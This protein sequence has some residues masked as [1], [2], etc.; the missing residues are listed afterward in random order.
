MIASLSDR[1]FGPFPI[2]IDLSDDTHVLYFGHG[3]KPHGGV[4]SFKNWDRKRIERSKFRDADTSFERRLP[5]IQLRVQAECL[6]FIEATAINLA[7]V[8]ELKVGRIA[9]QSYSGEYELS[10]FKNRAGHDVVVRIDKTYRPAFDRYLEFRRRVFGLHDTNLLF[11]FFGKGGEKSKYVATR[12]FRGLQRIFSSAGR[13]FV[14]PSMLRF[15]KGQRVIRLAA[16]GGDLAAVSSVLQ[17][18][19]DVVMRSYLVG[20]Q[21]M[22][23]IEFSKFLKTVSEAR[24]KHQVRAGGDCKKPDEPKAIPGLTEGTPKPD[25]INPAGCFFCHHYRG[26]KS[27]DYLHKILSYRAFLRLRSGLAASTS[28]MVNEVIVPTIERINDYAEEVANSDRHMQ[29]HYQ[30]V[31]RTLEGGEFH[32]TWRGW[33]EL[34]QIAGDESAVHAEH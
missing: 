27:R 32:R 12:G 20:S 13:P 9:Y 3:P 24:A 5:I 22:A 10:G 8:L 21:Q 29:D 14:M 4:N 26:V 11:P 34:L 1:M 31:M 25:C 2:R 16:T 28:S 30:A 17:N 33:I 23:T 19:I 15:A 6:R 18:T 7:P